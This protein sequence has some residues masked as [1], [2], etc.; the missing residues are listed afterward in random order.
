MSCRQRPIGPARPHRRR[1]TVTAFVLHYSPARDCRTVYRRCYPELQRII[2]TSNELGDAD[3]IARARLQ[4][5]L[6]LLAIEPW[7]RELAAEQDIAARS[8]VGKREGQ[9]D[10]KSRF[11]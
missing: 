10:S 9:R 11:L 1:G 4:A 6:D 2:S 8:A 3:D 5:I 7:L